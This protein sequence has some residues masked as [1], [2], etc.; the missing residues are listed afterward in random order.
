MGE[1]R[2]QQEALPY[3]PAA[4]V[5]SEVLQGRLLQL[6][7]NGRGAV[8][9]GDGGFLGFLA[10]YP[11]DGLFGHDRGVYSPL[12][13]HS[14]IVAGRAEIYEILYAK[15]AALWVGENL[16]S[17][18]L[19]MYAY[20]RENVDHWFWRGFGMRCV[21]AVCPVTR[22]GEAQSRCPVR[23]LGVEDIPDIAQLHS[24]HN[25][26]YRGSP[27][28]MPNV[29]TEPCQE[30]A[31]WM[32]QSNHHLWA[33]YQ[34]QQAVAYMRIEPDGESFIAEHPSM[35]NIT[36]AYVA[37]THRGAGFGTALLDAIKNWLY[38]QGFCLLGVDY[39]GLNPQARGFW[40]RHF[41]PYTFSL[42][43]RIDER[44]RNTDG[45]QH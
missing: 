28:F 4:T 8:A 37:P 7:Q 38:R 15:A 5:F 20:D 30:L 26:F 27:I 11:A 41:A 23:K 31:H 18:A 22:T 39:E 21:D 1:Y 33:A 3:L 19:T 10:G 36:G 32:E 45:G 44:I 2:R 43:R 25:A 29:W 16:L 34:D 17:H 12:Y 42:T 9:L 35:M 13:G 24:E 14:T 6:V 40:G